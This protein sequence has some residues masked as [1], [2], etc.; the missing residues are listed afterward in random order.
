MGNSYGSPGANIIRQALR[1]NSSGMING[2]DDGLITNS[3][4][5]IF[6]E[7][8]FYQPKRKYNGQPD[9][10]WLRSPGSAST[11][12]AYYVYSDGGVY[13]YFDSYVGNS[14]GY[15][16]RAPSSATA[17]R[18]TCSRVATSATAALWVGIQI[19]TAK[20]LL[21]VHQ[22]LLR[23]RC[24]LGCF[25]WCRGRRPHCGLFLRPACAL[26]THGETM[27]MRS[28]SSRKASLTASASMIPTDIT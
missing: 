1:V 28:Q 20:N 4:G 7:Y 9:Y 13:S 24:V 10:W 8:L 11:G 15:S 18:I 2:Y 16:L 21:S 6:P 19:P 22:Q 17:M 12:D 25:G 26:R 14:Y 27:S 5:I 3:Y 23:Q